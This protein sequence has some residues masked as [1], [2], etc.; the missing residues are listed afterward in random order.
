MQILAYTL[1]L[2][3][4]NL[5]RFAHNWNVGIMGSGKVEKWVIVIIPLDRQDNKLNK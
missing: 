3:G 1:T 4:R 2:K 5:A